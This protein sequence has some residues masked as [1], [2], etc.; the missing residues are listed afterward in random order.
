MSALNRSWVRRAIPIAALALVGIAILAA[1]FV[2]TAPATTSL[3][4]KNRPL[5]AWFNGSRT[6][7]FHGAT[8]QAA[9]EAF[10]ALGTN[11][12]PFLL[13]KLRTACG[14]GLTTG[15]ALKPRSVLD[16]GC[17]LPLSGRRER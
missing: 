7:F 10:D 5:D 16:C 12:G 1:H 9:Q 11:A 8:R 13:T 6:D 17:P 2:S 15:N 4:Y 14:D 3:T